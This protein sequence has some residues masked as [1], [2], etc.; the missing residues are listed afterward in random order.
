LIQLHRDHAPN[1]LNDHRDADND[2]PDDDKPATSN[3]D[4]TEP[5]QTART[6]RQGA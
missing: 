2:D 6:G 5:F 1:T 4:L 3:L